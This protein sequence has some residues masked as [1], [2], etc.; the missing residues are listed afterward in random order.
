MINLIGQKKDEKKEIKDIKEVKGKVDEKHS[1]QIKDLKE[2]KIE[3]LTDL[4]KRVQAEFENFK[5]REENERKI[6]VEFSNS[7]LIR[8][9]LPILDSIGS[10]KKNGNE[11]AKKGIE[12][13]E[14]QLIS[15]LEKYGLREINSVGKK[16]NPEF[17]ECLMK[18][19]NSE[20]E[21]E[22]VLEELQ[23]GFM[24]KDRVLRHS[25]V[26]I[27]SIEKDEEK[28]EKKNKE[29]LEENNKIEEQ[30]KEGI[31]ENSKNEN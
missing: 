18:E 29:E 11:E 31:E 12:L 9:L 17:H 5:K 23:K 30:K 4:V 15:V 28:I 24:L 16:F 8:N 13:I 2:A 6:F 26:K 1:E 14:K 10:A 3:E 7:E 19:N 21:D 20:K 27:N 25:K 22:I